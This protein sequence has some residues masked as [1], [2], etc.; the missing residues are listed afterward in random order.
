MAT[1]FRPM[2]EL[3]A[4]GKHVELKLDAG[5]RVV[6]WLY[7]G[8]PQFPRTFWTRGVTGRLTMVA[9]VGWRELPMEAQVAA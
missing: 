9:P 1:D 5:R 3:Q 6:G 7:C 8:H 2:D 4:D